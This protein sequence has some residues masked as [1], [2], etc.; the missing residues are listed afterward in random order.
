MEGRISPKK[1]LRKSML[2]MVTKLVI[3]T[4][5]VG[6]LSLIHILDMPRTFDEKLYHASAVLSI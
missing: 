4:S 1:L 6:I 2:V 5:S 3:T